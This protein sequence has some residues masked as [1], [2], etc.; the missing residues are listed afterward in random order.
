MTRPSTLARPLRQLASA[1]LV[2]LLVAGILPVPAPVSAA[3]PG[4]DATAEAATPPAIDAGGEAGP[5]ELPSTAYLEWLEHEHDR[6]GFTPGG[7]VTVG[8]KPRRGDAWPVGGQAPR[9][10]PAGRAAGRDMAKMANGT[11]W[12]ALPGSRAKTAHPPAATPTPRAE[13]PVDAP[14]N[15]RT[16]AASAVSVATPE[17]DPAFDLAAASGLRRQVYGFLPYWEVNGASSKLN[18]NV[19]STIAYFSVGANASGDLK[20][21]DADGSRTTGW[22]G[23]TSSSMTSVINA[24]H[25]KGTRVVLTVSVFAW[26]NT[27]A[28]VQRALLGSASARAQPR[29]AGRR[30]RPRPRRRRRQPR[31]RAAR[32]RL[33]RRVR[34]S[35]SDAPQRVQ[36][37]PVRLPGHLRHD[38]LHRELPARGLGRATGRG[39]DLRHGLRLPDRQLV[40]GRLRG[41]AERPDLRPRGHR[42]RL[43][44]PGA[45]VADHPGRAV[46]RPRL[47]H[48]DE[49]P[50]EPHDQRP[51]VRLQHAR[52]LRERPRLRGEVRPALGPGRA[53][54]VRR[55]PSPELHLELRLRDQLA[56]DLVRRRR[57]APPPL[58]ARQRLRPARR[59]HV[60][61]GLR[62]RPRRAVPGARRDVPRGRV[63]PDGRRQGASRRSRATRASSSVGRART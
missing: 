57:L 16:I 2:A 3:V 49:Q 26:T 40:D 60:G 27:Q 5:G 61:A 58:R 42:A 55:L 14:S 63:R 45:R 11:A 9:A 31:L 52:E 7:R 36:Q 37:G 1:A 29:E 34:G 6:I 38:R 20:K 50:A 13:A 28:R 23:W 30:R 48:R 19:L 62:R 10:L 24:A 35:A 22:G 25:R 32:Q 39:R 56:P 12:A 18:Y 41:P 53:E 43:Q 21:R 44:G 33:R 54:P 47:V 4:P 46:V 51:Q 15:D 17:P 8:F 59:R